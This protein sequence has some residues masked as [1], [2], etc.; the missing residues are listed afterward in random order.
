MDETKKKSK[1]INVQLVSADTKTALVEYDLKRVYIPADELN[2]GKVEEDVLKAGQPYG[3]PWETIDLKADARVFAE[4]LR[5]N[6]VWTH[7][8]LHGQPGVI[9]AALQAMYGIDISAAYRLAETYKEA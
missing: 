2:G 5:R 1:L 9:Q 3:V 7:K 8:D 6:G 4:Y